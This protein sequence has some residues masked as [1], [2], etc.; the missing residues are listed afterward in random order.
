METTQSLI[1]PKYQTVIPAKI[2][3]RLNLKKG[4]KLI[5][6]VIS[7]GNQPKIITEPEPK[8]W[9]AH[10]RGLGKNLWQKVD[11]EEYINNLRAEWLK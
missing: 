3:R 2:R 4:D 5:W 9:A 10:T 7:V 1:S 11:I 8:D 6:R